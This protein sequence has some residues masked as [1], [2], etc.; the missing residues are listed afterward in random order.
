[1]CAKTRHNDSC[2]MAFGRPSPAGQCP[3]CDELRNGAKP[4]A[5]WNAQK[6]ADESRRLAAIRHHYTSGECAR[7]CGPVCVRFDP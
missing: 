2:V 7:T 5:G 6:A 1:M 3:R 4:R